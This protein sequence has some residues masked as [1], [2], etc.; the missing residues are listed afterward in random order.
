M[1]SLSFKPVT[2]GM[3]RFQT[4]GQH[5]YLFGLLIRLAYEQEFKKLFT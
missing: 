3:S 1:A 5:S 2:R 4:I